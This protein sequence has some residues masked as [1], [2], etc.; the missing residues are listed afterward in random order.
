MFNVVL[1]DDYPMAFC[2][3]DVMNVLEKNGSQVATPRPAPA[4]LAVSEE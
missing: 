3:P 4:G 2:D 1:P